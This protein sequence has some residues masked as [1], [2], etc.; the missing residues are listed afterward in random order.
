MELLL[1]LNEETGYGIST[2]TFGV[3]MPNIT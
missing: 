2:K 3:F 1:K